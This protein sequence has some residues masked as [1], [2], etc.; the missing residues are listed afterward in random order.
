MRGYLPLIQTDSTTHMHGLA[1]YLK[2]GLPLVRD[3]SQENKSLFLSS[4]TNI[5]STMAF[6]PLG[7]SG[8]VVVSVSIDFPINSMPC[9]IT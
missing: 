4:D 5:C 3:L 1:V 7:N 9:S 8:H 2:E 6:P